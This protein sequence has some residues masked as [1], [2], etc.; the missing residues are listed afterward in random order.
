MRFLRAW[1]NE[2]VFS[3][4]LSFTPSVSFLVDSFS[5]VPVEKQAMGSDKP[6]KT[7]RTHLE[8]IKGV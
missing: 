5:L 2:V 1:L 8:R 7:R 4:I 3:S 6:S